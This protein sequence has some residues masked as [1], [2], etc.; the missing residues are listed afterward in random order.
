VSRKVPEAG[1]AGQRG[2]PCRASK[3]ANTWKASSI[4]ALSARSLNDAAATRRIDHA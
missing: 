3:N 2:R 1:S 4:A